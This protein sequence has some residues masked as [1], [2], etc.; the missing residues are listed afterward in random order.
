MVLCQV[1]MCLPNHRSLTE[2]H[3]LIIPMQHSSQGTM[4]DEDVWDEIQVSE[5][6]NIINYK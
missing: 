2:G 1:Y 4:L 5:E 3:C 6:I